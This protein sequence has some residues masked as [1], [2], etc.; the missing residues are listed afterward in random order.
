MHGQ[1]QEYQGQPGKDYRLNQPDQQ[2]QAEH[3][4]IRHERHQE[5]Y[6]HHQDFPGGHI[7]EQAES[8]ADNPHQF[9]DELQE[10]HK[11]VNQAAGPQPQQVAKGKELLEIAQAQDPNAP[12][13][14]KD[15]GYQSQGQ[16]HIDIG[17]GR[18]D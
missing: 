8:K 6:H 14:H 16:R 4:D 9:A 15:K 1:R 10:A 18:P 5:S 17:A 11:G 13:L 3:K 2:F 7:A 12:I